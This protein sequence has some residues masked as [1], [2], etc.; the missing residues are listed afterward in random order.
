[1]NL[2]VQKRALVVLTIITGAFLVLYIR[3]FEVMVVNHSYYEAYAKKQYFGHYRPELKRGSIYDR[4]GRVLAIDVDGYSVY[5]K[6]SEALDPN[7]MKN[8]LVALGITKKELKRKL[9]GSVRRVCLRR[10]LPPEKALVL[11]DST[12]ARVVELRAEPMRLYPKG[13]LASHILG[14]VGTEHKGL[15]GIEMLYDSVLRPD[16]EDIVI[17]KDRFGRVLYADEDLQLQGNSVVLTID[18]G[19]QMIL[20]DEMDRAMQKWQPRAATAVM[21]DPYTGQILAMANRPTYDPNNPFKYPMASWRN[22]A[23]TDP[24][25][26]GSTFKLVAATAALEEGIA[27]LNTKIDCRKGYVEVSGKRYYDAERHKGVLTLKEVLE[28]SSNVGT[29]KI[30]M[31]MDRKTFY[32]YMKLYGFGQKTG[33]DLPGESR[34]RVPPLGVIKDRTYA[35]LSIGYGVLT[36][37]VQVLRA[38][39]AVA[40]GGYLVRPY[41]VKEVYSAKGILLKKTR[42]ERVRILS[43]RTVAALKEAL[44]MVVSPEGTA[45]EAMIDG[46]LVAGK[47]GTSRLVD[48][49]TGRYSND[50]YVASFVGMVPVHRPRFVM[51]VVFWEPKGKYYG[52]EVAAPVFR[53]VAERVL[54]YMLVPRDDGPSEQVVLVSDG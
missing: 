49:A 40:N 50:R 34:G 31:R 12:Y 18:E 23:L 16:N 29:I 32:R 30:A 6:D 13:L 41:I 1:M 7:K 25:E 2:P 36:T 11:K 35:S 5:L 28:K 47:T 20:E 51:I 10:R 48:P 54:R 15:E 44:A 26:P 38:Y 8:L 33:I 52:G 22:R 37:A 3:L 42:V 21:M 46:N 39:A 43:A 19:L 24:Y 45:F 53:A 27:G 9:K 14:F 17:K 4:Q